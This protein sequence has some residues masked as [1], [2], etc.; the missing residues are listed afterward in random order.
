MKQKFFDINQMLNMKDSDGNTPE[1]FIT[2]S[3]VRGPGKTTSVGML[4]IKRFFNMKIEVSDPK[5]YKILNDPE[6]PNKFVLICR[7]KASIGNYAEGVLKSALYVMNLDYQVKE[8]SKID[9]LYSKVYLTRL[10]DEEYENEEENPKKKEE[11]LHCGYVISL[12][13]AYGIK[14]ISSIFIDSWG[15][16]QDEFMLQDGSYFKDEVKRLQNIHKSLARGIGKSCRYYPHFMMAN[17]IDILNP[18]FIA[19]G[20]VGKIQSNT[21]KYRG[22]GLVYLRYEPKEIIKEHAES[23]FD[24]A[25]SHEHNRENNFADNSWLVDQSTLVMKPQ[26]EWGS[27]YYFMQLHLERKYVRVCLYPQCGIWY[28]DPG[29]D[30]TLRTYAVT[31][32][33]PGEISWDAPGINVRKKMREIFK[34]GNMRFRDEQ[35]KRDYIEIF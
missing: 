18:Y 9:G 24:R 26:K 34:N 21:K 28:L 16:V 22:T 12:R 13:G 5:L 30:H 8:E 15:S 1:I 10:V 23:A 33:D 29:K 11:K 35:V 27:H 2:C 4:C 7:N 14:D 32:P 17:C 6:G 31:E 20:L 25:F 19:F 3:R